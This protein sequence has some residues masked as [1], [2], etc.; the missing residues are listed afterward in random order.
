[1]NW[2]SKILEKINKK[3]NSP[4][5]KKVEIKKILISEIRN[6]FP[7]FKFLRYKNNCYTFENIKLVNQFEVFEYIHIVFSLKKRYL[8][9]SIASKIGRKYLNDNFYN[10]GILNPHLNLISLKE[11]SKRVSIDKA[12]YF[13]NGKQ[14]TTKKIVQEIIKDLKKYGIP[15]LN[16]QFKS[17]EENTVIKTGFEF[18]NK[19]K[20][21][22]KSLSGEMKTHLKKGRLISTIEN[23][24]YQSLKSEL[25]KVKGIN[26]ETYKKIPRLT[27]D[28]LELYCE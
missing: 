23:K 10:T 21:N 8:S 6:E 1:M 16:E 13:H 3:D 12:Y 15:F 28:L 20:I 11:K 24:T 7:Q 27:Y 5:L 14:K 4:E 22:K 9:C 26:K 25:Q 18:I 19:L 17:L 2:Y